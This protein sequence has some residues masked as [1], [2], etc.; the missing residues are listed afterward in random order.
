MQSPHSAHSP[1]SRRRSFLALTG[2]TAAGCLAGL[3][4][5]T[6][7]AEPNRPATDPRVTDGEAVRLWYTAPAAEQSMVQPALPIGHGRL[8]ALVGGDPAKEALYITDATMSTGG[9]NDVLTDDG[10]FPYAREDFGSLTQLAHLTV[11]I[12]DHA[13]TAVT[14]Y[15]RAVDISNGLLTTSYV[16]QAA[17]YRRE[18]YASRPD[19]A[20]VLSFTQSGGGTYSGR[21][22]L[23]GAHG[24]SVT[25]DPAGG[26]ASF[27]A[28]LA[29]GRRYG[30]AVTASKI[31]CGAIGL[32]GISMTRTLVTPSGEVRVVNVTSGR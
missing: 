8:G 21:I 23:A 20:V 18:I 22:I 2:A 12:P 3:P 9:R 29:N 15:R 27:G 32:A 13:L 19:D 24:E 6:A 1:S 5:F 30:A 14:G 26:S 31:R 28:A 7:A 11:D 4:A 17:T 25:T 10:Q 16:H